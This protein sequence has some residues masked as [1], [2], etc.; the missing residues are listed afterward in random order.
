MDRGL[1]FD[2]SEVHFLVP[3]QGRYGYRLRVIRMVGDVASGPAVV[4][5]S[6]VS[7]PDFRGDHR[8]TDP[9]GGYRVASFFYGAQILFVTENNWI[10]QKVVEEDRSEGDDVTGYTKVYN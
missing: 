5:Y 3:E 8:C 2:L 10:G 9:Y 1:F 4:Q 6:G 7:I